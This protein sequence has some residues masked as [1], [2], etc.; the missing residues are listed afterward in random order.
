M[1]CVS[2]NLRSFCLEIIGFFECLPNHLTRSTQLRLR[3][4]DLTDNHLGPKAVA[5]ATEMGWVWDFHFGFDVKKPGRLT[6]GS[7]KNGGFKE[8]IWNGFPAVRFS[9]E[10]KV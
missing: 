6:A 10:Y 8:V 2:S 4:L 1:R 5:K 7:P 9:G 3:E